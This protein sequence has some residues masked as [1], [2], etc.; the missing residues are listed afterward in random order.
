MH[1]SLAAQCANISR[2]SSVNQMLR[3]CGSLNPVLRKLQQI[4]LQELLPSASNVA[5]VED[6]LRRLVSL[7]SLTESLQDVFLIMRQACKLCGRL[8]KRLP[9][10]RLRS[11]AN[12][13]AKGNTTFKRAIDIIQSCRK[14][15]LTGPKTGAVRHVLKIGN[16]GSQ[17]NVKRLAKTL[18]FAQKILEEESEPTPGTEFKYFYPRFIGFTSNICGRLFSAAEYEPNDC[19]RDILSAHIKMQLILYK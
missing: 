10:I 9:R 19:R 15:A 7:N 16:T 5:D 17:M 1:S 4:D 13:S 18:T 11:G 12:V 2:R 3:R 6:P 14:K 8:F